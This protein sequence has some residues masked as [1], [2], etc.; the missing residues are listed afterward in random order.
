M[1]SFQPVVAMDLS[2]VAVR[3][4]RL[5]SIL[6]KKETNTL[7]YCSS[8][9]FNFRYHSSCHISLSHPLRKQT[10]HLLVFFLSSSGQIAV[11][12]YLLSTHANMGYCVFCFFFCC[13]A[14]S[15]CSIDPKVSKTDVETISF[16]CTKFGST[17]Q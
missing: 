3:V 2:R 4:P 13:S 8:S 12:T 6:N 17:G 7:M 9:F 1:L 14:L 5:L 16:V 10:E 11:K 15:P